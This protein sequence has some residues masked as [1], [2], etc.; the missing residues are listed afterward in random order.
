[1][2]QKPPESQEGL[3]TLQFSIEVLV[4]EDFEL[5]IQLSL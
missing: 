1:M 4:M 2:R 3:K 5:P